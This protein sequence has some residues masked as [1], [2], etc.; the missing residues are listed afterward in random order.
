[1]GLNLNIRRIIFDGVKKFDGA[2][3]IDINPSLVCNLY[4]IHDCDCLITRIYTFYRPNK[5]QEEQ[6]DM[7]VI[8][9]KVLV[10]VYQL[11]TCAIYMMLITKNPLLLLLLAYSRLLSK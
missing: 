7:V 3:M 10:H 4:C 5:L 11:A 9:Q 1:M 2:D 6:D 8:F